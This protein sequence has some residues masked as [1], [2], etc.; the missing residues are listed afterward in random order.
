M[1]MGEWS[2]ERSRQ[3]V[4]EADAEHMFRYYEVA[5]V[6]A[7]ATPTAIRFVVRIPL[8]GAERIATV[9]RTI[10]LPVYVSVVGRHIQIEPETLYLAV[11]ESG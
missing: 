10:P 6:Q 11:S 4:A 9:F 2:E 1:R 3:V 5:R 7:Y 8:R